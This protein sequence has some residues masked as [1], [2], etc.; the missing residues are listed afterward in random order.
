MN[1]NIRTQKVRVKVLLGASG[2]YLA[3]GWKDAGDK[4][5]DD[6][7][8]DSIEELQTRE[9]WITAELPLPCADAEEFKAEIE[10]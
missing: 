4:E 3:Y 10:K 6:T 5:P 8:Y 2:N 7:L 1:T 9:Y